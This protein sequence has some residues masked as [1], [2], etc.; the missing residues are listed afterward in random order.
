MS[1]LGLASGLSAAADLI[2]AIQGTRITVDTGAEDSFEWVPYIL[3]T[4]GYHIRGGTD[5]IM[6]NVIAERGLGLPRR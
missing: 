1:K 5:Q 4:L 6:R 3:Q 2:C